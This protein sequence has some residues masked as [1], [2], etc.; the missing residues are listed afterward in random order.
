MNDKSRYYK[1]LFTSAAVWNWFATVA[2]LRTTAKIKTDGQS[3]LYAQLFF[4]FVFLF[5]VA[6]WLVSRD[7]TG[8]RTI[9]KLGVVGK[10][11][12]FLLSLRAVLAGK[13]PPVVAVAG[14]VDLVYVGLFVEFLS[15]KKSAD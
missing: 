1:I 15:N 10:L 9:V 11:I 7:L 8:N 14:T 5:G 2:G 4:V 12:V 13:A 3:R 6:Y